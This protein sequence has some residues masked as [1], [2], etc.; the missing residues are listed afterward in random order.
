MGH[1]STKALAGLQ[2]QGKPCVKQEL[3]TRYLSLVTT[4]ASRV[5]IMSVYG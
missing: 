5:S 4:I 2:S 1:G 3:I